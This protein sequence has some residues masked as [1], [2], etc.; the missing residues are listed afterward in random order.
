MV[1][2]K[3]L[4]PKSDCLCGM[5]LFMWY[6]PLFFK[7]FPAAVEMLLVAAREKITA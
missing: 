1:A 7:D 3:Q 5:G 6:R 4:D 2:Y